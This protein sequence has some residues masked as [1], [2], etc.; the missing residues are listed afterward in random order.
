[1]EK[2]VL[3]NMGIALKNKILRSAEVVRDRS[4]RI[5]D[6][7]TGLSDA[8]RA[9][10]FREVIDCHRRELNERPTRNAELDKVRFPPAK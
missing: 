7:V 9:P 2:I 5:V 3:D 6:L 10:L 8:E 1:M 4:S